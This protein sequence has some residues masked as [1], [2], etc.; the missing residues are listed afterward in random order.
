MTVKKDMRIPFFSGKISFHKRW[1]LISERLDEVISEGKFIDGG[2]VRSFEAAIQ[3]YTGAKHAVAVNNA[4]DALQIILKAAGIQP[5]DEVIVPCYSFFASASSIANVGATPVFTDIEPETYNICPE[6]IEEKITPNTKAIMVVHLFTQMADIKK[7]KEIAE[8]H[9]LI[10]LEDSA[11]A[12]GMKAE[13]IH[14]GLH[15]LAGVL[16]F[17]PTKTLG[18]I[19]DGGMILT[20]DDE[21]AKTC[22]LL[23][24]HGKLGTEY[25]HDI[26]GYN[27]R[28]DDIQAAVLEEK[29]RYLHEDIV[30]RKKL[31]E[32]YDERL[33]ELHP[34]VTTPT[35][36]EKPYSAVHVYYVYLIEADNRNELAAYLQKRGIETEA[37]Y[38]YPLHLQPCFQH[39][40]YKYGDFP[41]A[42]RASTRALGLPLYPDLTE[43]ELDYVCDVITDFYEG[44]GSL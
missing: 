42:E 29:L 44:G 28:M 38:P 8:K 14:A 10:L 25:Y 40:N 23:R 36:V 39:L 21:F 41:H 16:S 12:I 24:H 20:N 17:F 31:A 33:K 18:G 4:T 1:G 32:R 34:T 37:Y 13:G 26:I 3:N 22:R 19:G 9:N 15:G 2:A 43:D 11:E 7:L 30:R 5:G 35:V 27:S 6:Q